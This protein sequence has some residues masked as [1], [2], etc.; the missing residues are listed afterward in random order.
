MGASHSKNRCNY[1]TKSVLTNKN[2]YLFDIR[3]LGK[4]DGRT[5]CVKCLEYKLL[6]G[7]T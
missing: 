3:G 7:I 5:I 2:P 1:C 4:H 6:L